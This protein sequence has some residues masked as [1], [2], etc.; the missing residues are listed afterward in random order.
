MQFNEENRA[1]SIP[2]IHYF[3]R[4]NK[5]NQ[6]SDIEIKILELIEALLTY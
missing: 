3:V 6:K 2:D 1:E 5:Y 4:L